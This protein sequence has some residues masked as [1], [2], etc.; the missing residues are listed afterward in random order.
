MFFMTFILKVSLKVSLDAI[1]IALSP[2]EYGV[3]DIKEFRPISHVS[4]VHKIISKVLPNE[5]KTVLEK[6]ISRS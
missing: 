1:F 5:L 3:M 4:G 2:K 6:V